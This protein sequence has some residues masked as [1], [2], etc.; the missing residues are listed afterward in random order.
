MTPAPEPPDTVGEWV[1]REQVE[2]SSLELPELRSTIPGESEDDPPL[3]IEDH[4]DAQAAWDAWIEDCWWPWAEQD[5]RDQA[6]RRV[7]ADLFAMYQRQQ[8]LGETYEVVFGLGFLTWQPRNGPPVRRH[9]VTARADID[10]DA[11][12]GSLTVNAAAEGAEPVLEQDMLDPAD[13]PDPGELRSI[14]ETLE[15]IGASLWDAGPLDGLLKGWVHAWSPDG[16]YSDSLERP[17]QAG[18]APLVHFAPAL[19]L[20]PRTERSLV[21]AFQEII[22]QLESDATVSEGVARFIN[23]PADDTPAADAGVAVEGGAPAALDG[24]LYFP[25]PAN[26]AQ[27]QIAERLRANRGVLVQGPPGTGKSHTIVNLISHALAT[28]QRV[29]VTSHAPRALRVL[30]KMIRDRAPEIAPLAV[31]L[32]GDGRDALREMEAS[33]QGILDRESS[34][35]PL[36][37]RAAIER[38][39]EEL[40]QARRNEARVFR[41][42]RATR[43][44]ET[45]AHDDRYGYSGT[46][47]RIAETLNSE[48]EQLDW[49]PD[50]IQGASEPPLTADELGELV[51]L[52][53]NERVSEWEASGWTSLNVDGLPTAEAFEEAVRSEREARAAYDDAAPIRERAEYGAIG[54]IPDPDRRELLSRVDELDR[55]LERIERHPM[56]W[57]GAAAEDILAGVDGVWRQ[58]RDDTLVAAQAMKES[59]EWLDANPINPEPPE[60]TNLLADASDLLEHLN[61][62]GGWGFGPFRARAVKRALRVRELRVGGRRCETA[63]TVR[64]LVRR[65]RAEVE[66]RLL[67]ERWSRHHEFTATTFVDLAAELDDLCEPIKGALDALAVKQRLS[68]TLT[69]AGG[70][71]EPQWSDRAALRRLRETLA[72]VEAE[73]RYEAARDPIEQ[74]HVAVE[75]ELGFDPAAEDLHV[76]ISEWNPA[77]YEAALRRAL[78]HRELDERRIAKVLFLATLEG[79][80][81]KLAAD[82]AETSRDAAWDERAADFERAWNWRRAH[83]WVTRMASPVEERRL[84]LELDRAKQDIAGTL[85]RLAAEQAWSHSLNRM[86]EHE[87]GSLIAWRLAMRRAGGRTGRFAAQYLREARNHLNE[88]RTA[89]PAWVMPLH[90]VAETMQPGPEPLFDIAIIDEASQSGPEALLLAWLARRVVVV[91]DDEQISP[92]DARVR[93]EDVNRLREQY[94]QDIPFADAF[95]ARGG[96][97]FELAEIF[98][99]E[100]IRLR[101]HFRSMPEIIQFS[102]QLSYASQPLIPLRQFGADRL[103]PVVTRHV[104]DGYQVGTAGR[105]VNRPEAKAV[106][107]EIVRICGDPAYE[108][109]TIGV[110]SLLGGTQA[111]E[112]ESLLLTCIDPEEW[113]HRRIVCGD[114]YAFQGDERDVMLLSLVSA[115]SEERPIVRALTDRA[116][117]QRF[118]VA[119]SRARDQMVL[120]HTATLNELSAHPDCVRRKLL[121][122]CLDPQ[123]ATPCPGGL[124]VAAIERTAHETHRELRN[125]PPPFES[126]FELDV[127]LH[128][129]RRSYCVTPQH[130]VNRYRI[131]LVV[132]GVEGALAVECDGDFWLGPDRYEA[133][134]ARERDLQRCGWTFERI[135]EGAFRLDP[136]TALEDLWATLERLRIFPSA[137]EQARHEAPSQAEDADGSRPADRTTGS[138]SLD[139]EFPGMLI[140]PETGQL[141]VGG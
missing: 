131:D 13:H 26:D 95:G 93:V 25:L 85:E 139:G 47:A 107:A 72:A 28:G 58:L 79:V 6:V 108:G 88:A 75:E 105:A 122:Y 76:A 80:A 140:D 99:G 87:K 36:E 89:I 60:P 34:W 7:Y 78:D 31:V 55:L 123:V 15:Q 21:R 113:E 5:R 61:T 37:S 1:Q 83:A 132:W 40:D 14:E 17:G 9:V 38:L 119:A 115:P 129:A 44:Q 97:F 63:E 65:L 135:K 110:I 4:T 90:R 10:F 137:R 141:R 67:Q 101:E 12:S 120:F 100:R 41:E 51:A 11:E 18:P 22:G 82:L 20:R 102:N 2:D 24:E 23:P 64:D 73:R 19:I 30:H 125:Q 130:E 16:A 8:G 114:A 124:D 103:E 92:T 121:A 136:D 29:L 69:F 118:N 94:L 71:P 3:R 98:A 74:W 56:A 96:S 50:H 126:W 68:W 91:G 49:V 84:R 39:R 138:E 43:E 54:T 35:S 128:I 116:A 86:T 32:P 117:R 109:K 106:V 127:F 48:R 112:I 104:P 111:K 59:A 62:G 70:N 45:Y 134:V 46:L 66:L 57:T 42:L 33:V 53:R 77:A 81:P 27:K 52:L 133:D